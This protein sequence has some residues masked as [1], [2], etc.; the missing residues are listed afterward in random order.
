[1]LGMDGVPESAFQDISVHSDEDKP[2]ITLEDLQDS[3]ISLVE[4]ESHDLLLL[5]V[6]CL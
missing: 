6:C 1:M 5:F 3:T 2:G 4:K